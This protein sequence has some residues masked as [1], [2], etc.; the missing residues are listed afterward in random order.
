MKEKKITSAGFNPVTVRTSPVRYHRAKAPYDVSL[1][2][3]ST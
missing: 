1:L 2:I 3:Y